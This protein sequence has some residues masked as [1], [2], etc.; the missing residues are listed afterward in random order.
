MRT[1][2]DIPESLINDGLKVTHMKTKTAL[3]KTAL[4]ELIRKHTISELKNYQGKVDLNID[5]DQLRERKQ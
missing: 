4:K 1:T 2:L 5:L 3:I